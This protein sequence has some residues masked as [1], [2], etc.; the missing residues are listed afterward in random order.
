MSETLREV[1]LADVRVRGAVEV[2]RTARGILPHRLPAW[3]RAQVPDA[4]MAQTSAE[5]AGVRLAFRTAATVIEL[6][7]SARRMAPDARSPLPPSVYELAADGS[8]VAAVAA[9]SGSRYLFTFDD[10]SGTV[11]DGPPTLVRFAGLPAADTSYELWLPYTDAVEVLAVRA[12]APVHPAEEPVALRWL[13]H[14]SSIS[15]GYRADATSG[16]WPVVAAL[17]AG[18]ELTNLGF[19][20][21]AMLDPFTARTIRDR[22][23]DLI[24]V[25]IGINLV[26]GDVMRMRAFRPALD[27][28]LDTVREG[29]PSTPIVVISPIFCAPVETAAGPTVQDPTRPYEWSIAGGTEADVAQGKLSLG[30]IRAAIADIVERRRTADDRLRHVHG[31]LLYGPDDART[32]PLPDNLHPGPDVQRLMGER[33]SELVLHPLLAQ[34]P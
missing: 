22:P 7:V 8:V 34:R 27:G 4:F 18:V 15:H 25:K 11:V 23:T 26:N 21:S 10:P 2:E 6:E 32:L 30:S 28:F 9:A 31:H 13:H 19:S 12:D 16:T 1:D 5:S 20:G 24:T 3:A 14:G 17:A 29:H 33:F